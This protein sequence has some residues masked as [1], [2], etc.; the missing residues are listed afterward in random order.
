MPGA[1]IRAGATGGAGTFAGGGV[2]GATG[3]AGFG[4]VGA[5]AVLAGGGA[6]AD[7]KNFF[8]SIDSIPLIPSQ[9]DQCESSS[10]SD[11]LMAAPS[12]Q[13]PGS[14]AGVCCWLQSGRSDWWRR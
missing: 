7:R 5:G 13:V 14:N 8:K 2:T 6:D 12:L 4:G 3:A 9:R 11:L 1:G 10:M